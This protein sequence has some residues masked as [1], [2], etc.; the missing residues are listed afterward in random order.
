MQSRTAEELII[1]IRVHSRIALQR[2]IQRKTT[3][4]TRRSAT[5]AGSDGL[6]IYHVC[7]LEW[8]P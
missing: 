7:S 6:H 4:G 1:S 2:A 5:A 8:L 3:H